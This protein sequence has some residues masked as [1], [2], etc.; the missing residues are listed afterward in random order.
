MDARL[1]ASDDLILVV[2]GV[3]KNRKR[4]GVRR[5]NPLFPKTQ[6]PA[7]AFTGAGFEGYWGQTPISLRCIAPRPPGEP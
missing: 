5:K 2:L 6:K 3:K 4:I 1:N 7:K